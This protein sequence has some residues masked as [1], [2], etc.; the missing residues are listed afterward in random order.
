MAPVITFLSDYGYADEFVGV[1][2]GVIAR[3]CP[4]ARV[5]DITHGLDRHAV[6]HAAV[7]LRNALRFMPVGVHLAVVD[8]DVGAERRAVALGLGDERVLVG[9]DNGLLALAAA[10][11]GGVAQAIDIGRSRYRLEP[12]SATFHGRDLFA[13]VAA[14]LAAGAELAEA[15]DPIE[16][17]EL[18]TLDLPQP[19]LG[20]E[21][22]VA[23][24]LALD[25]FGNLTLNVSHDELAEAAL[26]LGRPLVVAAGGHSR[27]AHF[28]HT[29]ADVAAGELL[30]YEDASRTLAVAVN[31]GSAAEQLSVTVGDELRLRPA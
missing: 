30:V 27:A 7:I 22:I 9:P 26:R 10:D 14:Q 8:P 29:F 15:G 12:V 19:T 18:A 2:H 13:P 6:Q 4:Q 28:A 11:G 23:H 5:I 20:S 16:P 21:E 17:A 25:R 3:I 24:V 1:C 31:R